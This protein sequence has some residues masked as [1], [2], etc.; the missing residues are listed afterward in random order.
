M[1]ALA[2]VSVEG[3]IRSTAILLEPGGRATVLNEPGPP[4]AD[5]ESL[6]ARRERID[7]RARVLEA[8][9]VAH[10]LGLIG[11]ELPEWGYRISGLVALEHKLDFVGPFQH[12][13]AER[14]RAAASGE[15]G[16]EELR[17]WIDRRLRP[18]G[19]DARSLTADALGVYFDQLEE[20]T[21]Q[22]E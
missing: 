4:L 14:A 21:T 18:Y 2:G 10:C 15:I 13:F 17:D 9:F 3:E 12:E 5:G 8:D 6:A 19:R 20:E 1:V 11:V 16:V 7:E 22:S